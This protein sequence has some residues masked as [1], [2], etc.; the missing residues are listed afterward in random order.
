MQ[1]P[2]RSS[3]GSTYAVGGYPSYSGSNNSSLAEHSSNAAIASQGKDGTL[4]KNA[5]FSS[6][7]V[8]AI[9][10]TPTS[11][12]NISAPTA[13][14][15]QIDH[16]TATATS[17]PTAMAT[18]I[19]TTSEQPVVW[20]NP[21]EEFNAMDWNSRDGTIRASCAQKDLHPQQRSNPMTSNESS[22]TTM[23]IRNHHNDTILHD[24][25]G[26]PVTVERWLG[27][28]PLRSD[29][30]TRP[31]PG[32]RSLLY[33]T[34]AAVTRTLND[35]FGYDGWHLHIVKTEQTVCVQQVKDES[36][37]SSPS[38][39]WHV[40]Y[41]SHVRVTHRASGTV[42]EDVG[43]G[44]AVDR[45]LATA[46]GH[47]IKASITDALKRAAR[48]F[49][50]KLG[51]ALYQGNGKFTIQKAPNSIAEALEKFDQEQLERYVGNRN[52]G[53]GASHAKA[54][55]TNSASDTR[56]APATS[57]STKESNGN[58]TDLRVFS[59][60]SLQPG[61]GHSISAGQTNPASANA[62]P[63]S[64]HPPKAAG[65]L[66]RPST[67]PSHHNDRSNLPPRPM[68]MTA[69]GAQT[70]TVHQ[71]N[72]TSSH[73]APTTTTATVVPSSE[74]VRNVPPASSHQSTEP[75]AA[76]PVTASNYPAATAQGSAPP[77]ALAHPNAALPPCTAA[78]ALQSSM[79]ASGSHHGSDI[80]RPPAND[81]A[82]TLP[83]RPTT[84]FGRRALPD[85]ASTTTAA[86]PAKKCKVNPYS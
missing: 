70:N 56:G 16:M 3:A 39:P 44:D 63:K 71:H 49:G 2:Q 82:T 26:R 54:G 23:Y 48:H 86:A 45:V 50:D 24:Y 37:K 1:P 33:L 60:S 69:T 79:F 41:L 34:G 47:A 67:F 65:A 52:V 76:A 46:V 55:A 12:K 38:L 68:S 19:A 51:N 36:K 20:V 13:N 42:K 57:T 64:Y 5:S 77:M 81:S 9:S 40:A 35:T 83:P 30:M 4:N 29:L 11:K 80:A 62:E 75:R 18:S 8:H 32:G 43:A 27:T 78:Q 31:G 53:P 25:H 66:S 28:A 15:Y 74:H 7:S 14:A 73:Q 22:H 61:M 10:N 59:N 84:S 21:L 6:S 17:T 72:P 85:D 58:S